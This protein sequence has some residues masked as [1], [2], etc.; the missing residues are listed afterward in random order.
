MSSKIKRVKYFTEERKSKVNP[1]NVEKYKKYLRSNIIKDKSVE[2]TTYKVYEN[3]FMQFLVFLSEEWD[4]IDLYSEEFI[5]NALDIMES[6]M[7]FCQDTLLNN[8]KAINNKCSAI[9]SFFCWSV[10]RKLIPF[11]PFSGQLD[12]MKGASEEKIRDSY[13][14]TEEQ[15]EEIKK[16][17]EDNPKEYSFQDRLLFCIA[18]DSANRVGGL[19]RLTIASFNADECIFSD[20]R[21]KRGKIVDVA[22]EEETRDMVEEWLSYRQENMDKLEV[23]SIFIT[24]YGGKYKTMTKGTIEKKLKKVGNIVGIKDFY[25]HCTRKSRI[26]LIVE[27]TGDLS[28][29][30][31]YANHSSPDTTSRHY[32]KKKSKSETRKQIKEAMKIK[33]LE[34]EKIKEDNGDL[35]D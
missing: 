3:N 1:K 28:L 13:F 33:R 7:A 6:F 22:I 17:M 25:A 19:E 35:S 21:E 5:E 34:K 9:S 16:Y 11:H 14:L 31:S 12:R 30:Q 2:G 8:K 26:N 18:I 20:I 32:V 27:E 10:K 4:N 29:A 15:I 23:D 24:Y